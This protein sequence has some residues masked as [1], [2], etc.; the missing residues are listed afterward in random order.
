MSCAYRQPL[1]LASPGADAADRQGLWR[2]LFNA[3]WYA[4][5]R[6]TLRDIDRLVAARDG[7]INDSLDREIERR[8]LRT[9][10]GPGR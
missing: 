9:G 10:W 7:A 3:V 4:Q 6:E 5:Q 2:R 1:R 8:I